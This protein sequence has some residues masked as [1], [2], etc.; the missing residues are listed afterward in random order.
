ME[1]PLGKTGQKDSRGAAMLLVTTCAQA[2]VPADFR[3]FVRGGAGGPAQP[4]Q[5]QPGGR[6]SFATIMHNASERLHTANI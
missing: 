3:G 1:V 6:C 4:C 2:S 5:L